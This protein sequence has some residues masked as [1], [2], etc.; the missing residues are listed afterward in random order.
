MFAL[1]LKLL[2][3]AF[4][5]LTTLLPFVE[6]QLLVIESAFEQLEFI[7]G[8]LAFF[9]PLVPARFEECHQL[10]QG[11]SKLNTRHDSITSMIS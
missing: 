10:S 2:A 9:F 5:F 3:L 8:L 4:G 1:G 11:T 6:P 7:L